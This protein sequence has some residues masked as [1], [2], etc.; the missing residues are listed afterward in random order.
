MQK[1]INPGCQLISMEIAVKDNWDVIVTYFFT[2]LTVILSF[3]G[4][5]TCTNLGCVFAVIVVGI[6]L[7]LTVAF[8]IVVFVRNRM[9]KHEYRKWLVLPV[10]LVLVSIIAYILINVL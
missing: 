10:V 8:L 3:W 9:V 5:S 6:S 4:F 2:I 7:L 1:H